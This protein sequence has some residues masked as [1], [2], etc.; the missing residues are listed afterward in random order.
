MKPETQKLISKIQSCKNDCQ[1]PA[2]DYILSYL[3]SNSIY[4]AHQ[5]ALGNEKSLS[6]HSELSF[7]L[8]SL[9]RIVK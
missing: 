5:V 9:E 2:L 3:E 7:V 6:K 8:P 1:C 4:S